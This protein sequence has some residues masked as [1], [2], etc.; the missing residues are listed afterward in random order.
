M[1][2]RRRLECMRITHPLW[3]EAALTTLSQHAVMQNALHLHTAIGNSALTSERM[4]WIVDDDLLAFL[5]M[6]S[7]LARRWKNGKSPCAG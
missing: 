2:D 4:I 1:F 7:M 3:H 6:G 5:M